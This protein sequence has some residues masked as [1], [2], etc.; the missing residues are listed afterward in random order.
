MSVDDVTDLYERLD[1]IHPDV[2][3]KFYVR[4]LDS[5]YLC[6]LHIKQTLFT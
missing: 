1:N 3:R 4:K 5:H 2:K 6:N